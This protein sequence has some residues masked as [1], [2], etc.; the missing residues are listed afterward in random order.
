MP[1]LESGYSGDDGVRLGP[2]KDAP[3]TPCAGR[4]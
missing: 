1:D 3:V 4:P 2:V